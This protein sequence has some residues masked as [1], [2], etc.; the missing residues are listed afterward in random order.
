MAVYF[1]I[2]V[3]LGRVGEE[4][5]FVRE[6]MPAIPRWWRVISVAP[7]ALFARWYH[8]G[9]WM[10][11]ANAFAVLAGWNEAVL[12]AAF[13]AVNVAMRQRR[14]PWLRALEGAIVA[15]AG[16]MVSRRV[17]GKASFAHLQDADGKIQIYVR[18]DEVGE[19][20][21]ADFKDFDL[22]D[23]LGVKG[24]VFRT[25]AGEVSIHATEV[26]LLTKCL[27]PLPEKFHGLKDTDLRYRQ[28]YV[29]LIVSPEVKDTFVKRSK[30]IR[31]IRDF[32]EESRFATW[33]YRIASNACLK[34]R[35]RG[36][37]EPT[38]EQELSLDALMPHPDAQGRRPEIPDW[39]TDAE[40]ALLRGELGAQLEAAID[41]LPRAYKVVLVLRDV[42][43][44][45]AE[46][47]A[48]M[49]KLSVAAVKSRLH[50][51]RVFVRRELSGYFAEGRSGASD[52]AF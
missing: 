40:Q 10:A 37:H 29:D 51:A 38:P 17:M 25:Q 50:R 23:V 41:R 26:T 3:A 46:E 43:G 22:G 39:S 45:S 13:M 21:Y 48:E 1:L 7:V 34:K 5:Y 8:G 2:L 42:E 31:S 49:L 44:F 18:R 6:A 20:P 32:R 4:W 9:I 36:V 11:D 47:T 12:L 52:C 19:G 28:R 35:R 16:R 30:I 27:H 24:R 14:L 15:V 33:L